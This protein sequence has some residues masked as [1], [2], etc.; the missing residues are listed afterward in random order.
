MRILGTHAGGYGRG[1]PS[2]ESYATD[3]LIAGAPPR[4]V[5]ERECGNA[6]DCHPERAQRVEDLHPR[7]MISRG[8]RRGTERTRRTAS[9][10]FVARVAH[11]EARRH[12]ARL[13]GS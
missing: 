6:R 5:R 2:W 1:E 13:S 3:D 8:E 12:G 4:I 7:A 10:G 11:A 9:V